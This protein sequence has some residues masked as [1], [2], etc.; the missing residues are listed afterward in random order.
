MYRDVP[1][2]ALFH[3]D[4]RPHVSFFSPKSVLGLAC[5][6][7]MPLGTCEQVVGPGCLCGNTGV[8]FHKTPLVGQCFSTA[9]GPGLRLCN[10]HGGQ[11]GERKNN[12]VTRADQFRKLLKLDPGAYIKYLKL[13]Q[14]A[15]IEV[16]HAPV[17][18]EPPDFNMLTVVAVSGVGCA[19]RSRAC[20][21]GAGGCEGGE[22]GGRGEGGVKEVN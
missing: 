17:S 5:N 10:R 3:F 7:A 14:Q 11:F 13:S 16:C 21:G 12:P 4:Q 8:R 6:R 1:F 2:C 22:D 15:G 9:T 18:P 19:R 20:V